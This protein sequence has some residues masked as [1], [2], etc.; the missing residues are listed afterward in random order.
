MMI[1]GMRRNQ[2][3]VKSRGSRV[4]M[5]SWT[6]IRIMALRKLILKSHRSSHAAKRMARMLE[7]MQLLSLKSRL[8][9]LLRHQTCS[10]KT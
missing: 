8:Q 7:T 10:D 6:K 5:R 4:L 2:G 3:V 1:T 9:M